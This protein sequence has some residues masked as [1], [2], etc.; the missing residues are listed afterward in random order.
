MAIAINEFNSG[1]N[2]N[3]K[4][5]LDIPFMHTATIHMMNSFSVKFLVKDQCFTNWYVNHLEYRKRDLNEEDR[6]IYEGKLSEK[7]CY[8][9][10]LSLGDNKSPGNDG[11]SKEFYVRFFNEIHPFLVEALNCSFQHGELPISERQAVITLIEKKGKDKRFIKNWRPISL[12]NVDTKI[13]SKAIALRLKKVIPKLIH[14]DQTAYINNR[15]IGEAIRLISD[16][17]E[18]T[19]EK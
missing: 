15:Y 11:L 5:A 9:A 6:T 19:A 1:L 7:E 2:R 12:M 3:Q 14:C 4:K 17:L 18:Y 13:A 8:D 10:L 16:M